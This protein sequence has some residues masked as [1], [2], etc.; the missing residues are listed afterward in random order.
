[1]PRTETQVVELSRRDSVNGFA[2]EYDESLATVKE[3]QR[4]HQQRINWW[5]TRV[6][7]EVD[8]DAA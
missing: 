3:I 8:A 1:M 7:A 5:H 4:T 6:D 2:Y